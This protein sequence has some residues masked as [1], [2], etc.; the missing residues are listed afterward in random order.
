M[1]KQSKSF[2]LTFTFTRAHVL[3]ISCKH[4]VKYHPAAKNRLMVSLFLFCDKKTLHLVLFNVT[5]AKISITVLVIFCKIF[6][7]K[8]FLHFIFLCLKLSE[9]TKSSAVKRCYWLNGLLSGITVSEEVQNDL[10]LAE[11]LWRKQAK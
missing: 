2:N 8:R 3:H 9:L 4:R 1:V 7:N 5:T 6:S 10:L 11:A